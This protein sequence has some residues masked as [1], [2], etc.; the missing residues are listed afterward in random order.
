MSE[1]KPKKKSVREKIEDTEEYKNFQPMNT[2][3]LAEKTGY[4][5]ASLGPTLLQ[6]VEAGFLVRD[7]EVRK[8]NLRKGGKSYR[9]YRRPAV[10]RLKLRL[11]E[12]SEIGINHAQ[13]RSYLR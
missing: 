9:V 4:E 7:G 8:G 10:R 2:F 11:V 13:A 6:M 12:D 3:D 1:G 5:P